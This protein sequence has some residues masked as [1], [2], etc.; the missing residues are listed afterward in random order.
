MRNPQKTD[1]L[2]KFRGALVLVYSDTGNLLFDYV[3]GYLRLLTEHSCGF[4]IRKY[5]QHGLKIHADRKFGSTL[6]SFVG[7]KS[8]RTNYFVKG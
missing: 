5:V 7:C 2:R 8:M 4:K 3:R 1:A 6:L